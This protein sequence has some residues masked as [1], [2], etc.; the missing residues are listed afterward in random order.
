MKFAD[1][2]GFE[3]FG[4][5]VLEEAGV[6]DW[7]ELLQKVPDMTFEDVMQ[8]VGTTAKEYEETEL[9]SDDFEYP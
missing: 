1:D 3:R 8:T 7:N 5:T 2:N 4:A 6:K 9:D